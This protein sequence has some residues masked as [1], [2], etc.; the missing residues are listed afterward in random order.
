MKL[1]NFKTYKLFKDWIKQVDWKKF[2]KIMII[3]IIVLFLYEIVPINKLTEYTVGKGFIYITVL[4][5][6][7][8]L[9][10]DSFVNFFI[11]RINKDDYPN[12]KKKRKLKLE[13]IKY[14]N[15]KLFKWKIKKQ[16][17]FVKN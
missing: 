8:I 5:F 15:K 16:K 11:I 9:L 3:P 13:E 14:N 6:M 12:N 7:L 4:I 17:K 10:L 2:F 1:I